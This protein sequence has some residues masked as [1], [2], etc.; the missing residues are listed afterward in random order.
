[1]AGTL[2]VHKLQLEIRFIQQSRDSMVPGNYRRYTNMCER[3][4]T[5]QP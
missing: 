1:M 4:V 3:Y 5:V 2:L